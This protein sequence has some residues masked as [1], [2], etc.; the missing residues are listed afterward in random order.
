MHLMYEINGHKIAKSIELG[1]LITS[2]VP[3][4]HVVSYVD[5]HDRTD[6]YLITIRYITI[7]DADGVPDER[8]IEHSSHIQLCTVV[9]STHFARVLSDRRQQYLTTCLQ[10]EMLRDRYIRNDTI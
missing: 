6:D 10:L 1:D 9:D 7:A 3:G 4:Y 2:D 5:F 8:G